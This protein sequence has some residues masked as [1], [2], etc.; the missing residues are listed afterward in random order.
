MSRI[1]GSSYDSRLMSRS[2]DG[3][4]LS[5][6]FTA[7][8]GTLDPR[9]TFTRAS[10]ATFIN[11]SGYVEFAAANE[12]TY[13]QAQDNN[14]FWNAYGTN[15]VRTS[16]QSDPDGGTNA[17]KLVFTATAADA[18]ISRTVAINNGLPYTISMWMRADSGTVTNVRFG[19]GATAAGAFFPTLTTTWQRVSLSFTS[20]GTNDG[21]EIRVLNSGSPQTATFYV[22]GAQLEPGS[23]VRA[24]QPAVAATAFYAPRFDYDPTT[25]AAKGLLLEAP[26]TNLCTY[27]NNFTNAE[28]TLDNSGAT[29]PVPSTVS[30]TGPDGAATVVRI[31]F[32]KTGGAFSRIRRTVS[33]SNG[34]YIMSV[35]MKANTA[36]GAASTQNVGLR[37]GASNG[38]NCVVTTT[39]Q[40]F[41]HTY[42]VA[43]GSAEFQ[44]MLW[45]NIVANDETADVLVY[46]AQTELGSIESSY[47]PT[48]VATVARA[49]DT[50]IIAAGTNFSSWYTGATSGTF[51]SNWYGSAS[52]TT[53][54]SVIATSDQTTKHLHMYQTASALTLRLADFNAVGTV[55]TANSLTAGALTKG[56]FSYASTATSLCLNGGT[57]ATGTLAFSAAPTWL[58]IGGPSTNGTSITD[59][60]VMLNNS[61]RTLKYFPARL[62]DGQIQGLTT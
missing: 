19:R 60:T 32:N 21:I 10:N 12:M 26:A 35:W 16:A 57:V 8:G 42:A 48:G 41:T 30:Q 43:D 29:N 7:M 38:V 61:I 4:T 58:S 51:V 13:S 55:T 11:S 49:V 33:V 25:I 37:L 59:T 40:R 44:I 39:W 54:R 46:G 6:D 20:N 1:S 5:L 62:S 28:W 56:A 9:I 15:V 18:V 3:S 31:T 2:G 34:T 50:A 24:Y 47:I 52:T 27:S 36:N 14:S 17:V 45:D 22:Y 53:A 23:S